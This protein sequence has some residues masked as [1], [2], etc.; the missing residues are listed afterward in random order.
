MHYPGLQ[1]CPEKRWRV[2][3]AAITACSAIS[4]E[5]SIATGQSARHNEDVSAR[6]AKAIS[7]LD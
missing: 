1:S 5:D 7:R 4:V 3:S 6:V 2:F